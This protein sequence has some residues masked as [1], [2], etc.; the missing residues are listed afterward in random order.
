MSLCP[1]ATTIRHAD[2]RAAYALV[3]GI[4]CRGGGNIAP[5]ICRTGIRCSLWSALTSTC[6]KHLPGSGALGCAWRWYQVLALDRSLVDLGQR[7]ALFRVRVPCSTPVTG[8]SV[9]TV[10]D[11][12]CLIDAAWSART[13][14]YQ[15]KENPHFRDVQGSP[16]PASGTPRGCLRRGP[17]GAEGWGLASRNA[18]NAAPRRNFYA[19]AH[20]AVPCTRLY[21]PLCF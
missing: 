16:E 18:V 13:S 20:Q 10:V 9:F 3:C 6:V 5:S 1:Q 8:G 17:Y 7:R 15:P 19:C 12:P 11:A 14:A 21:S 2:R 4:G